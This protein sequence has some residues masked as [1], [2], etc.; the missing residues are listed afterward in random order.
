MTK[1]TPFLPNFEAV[2]PKPSF[3]FPVENPTE[4]FSHASPPP[5][6]PR[7]EEREEGDVPRLAVFFV[8]LLG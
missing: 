8:F 4:P 3:F 7:R 2:Q 6:P 1:I 5:P